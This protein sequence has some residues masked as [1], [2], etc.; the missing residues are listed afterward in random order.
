M[1]KLSCLI[2]LIILTGLFS[3]GISAQTPSVRLES[4][5][6]GLSSPIFLTNAKD[7][8][9]RIFVVQRGGII[10]VVQPG[11]TTP[12]DFLNISSKVSTSGEGGLLGLAF[13]PQYASNQRFFVYYA[14][15]GDGAIQISE[16]QASADPN[17]AGT[18]EK[19]LITIPHSTNNNHYGGTIA[20][21]SDGFLYA[22]TG[23]GGGADDPE[24]NAQ[25]IN[26]LLGKFI[27]IDVDSTTG[28]LPYGIP[29]D[30]PFVGVAGADEI[31]ALGLRNPYRWSFDR[32]GTRQLY[33]GDVGQGAREEVDIIINGGNYGWRILEGTI[34]TPGVNPNCTAPAGYVPPIF[35]YDSS[36]GSRCS[37][38]GGYVYR[39][40][41]GT[42]PTGGY[43][44]G[45]Y[46]TGEILLYN[47]GQQSVL[48][49]TTNFNLVSFGEDEAG[50]IYVVKLNVGTVEKL[51]PLGTTAA[52]VTIAGRA[53]TL[54]G[55]GIGNV[56]ITLTDSS[57][58][59]RIARTSAF[60]YYRF[61]DV[62]AGNTY[63]ISVAN[64]RFTFSQPS[65]VLS[66]NADTNAIDFIANF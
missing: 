6:S 31:F 2:V 24:N 27:R 1:Q 60:G 26:V 7:G 63:I 17:V 22:G 37:I 65:Q 55:R 45:D 44:Y 3:L 14:R 8:S 54:K 58:N 33:A 49:D 11:S 15:T 38:T 43:I 41:R 56:I 35:E 34:C 28:N 13:H 47:G 50:E 61:N 10:K 36:S 4:F 51:A 20:F 46:C 18:S 62:A 66:V 59:V 52:G 5:L 23:D 9:N 42:V 40:T 64:K 32:G 25:N 16:F 12:T 30:N 53:L 19:M 29:S 48:L 39:G 21:G 57:G